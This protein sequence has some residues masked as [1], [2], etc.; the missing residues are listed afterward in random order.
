MSVEWPQGVLDLIP[1]YLGNQRWYANA[2]APEAGQ[3]RVERTAELWSDDVG[4]R[5]LLQAVVAAG[6]DYYHLLVGE[7]PA[8]ERAEFLH[9][10]EDAVLGVVGDAYYYDATLDS[11]LARA[12]LVVA[13]D[14]Q[15]SAALARQL[16]VE[17]SNTSLVY[18]DRL[19]LKVFRHLQ[20]GR[21]PDVEVTTALASAGFEH[22]AKPLVTWRDDRFDLAFGQRFLAGGSEGWA[23]ALT[24]LRDFYNGDTTD[25]AE[26]GGDFAAEAARLGRV[27][28]EMHLALAESFG[29]APTA[30]SV[31]TWARLVADI[32]E[33]LVSASEVA[34]KDLLEGAGSLLRRLGSVREPGPVFRVHGDY[35][36]GQVMRSD[37]GWF[38]LD[39]EGEPTKPLAERT[40]PMSPVKDVSSMIRSFH[41]AS[42]HVLA[43][44]PAQ[45][46]AQIESLPLAWE[47]HNRQAFLGGYQ[48]ADGIQALLPDPPTAAAAMVAYEL[49]KSLYELDYEQ[50][51]RPEWVSIPLDALDRIIY[52]VEP[53]G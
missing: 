44:R 24:S 38:V 31:S 32:R 3:V 41:Y 7:R 19:I 45:D 40:A 2:E 23:L 46:W 11:E 37:A 53:G 29:I 30:E 33:R 36:L 22:V 26:A 13:S 5:R 43:E 10:R 8:G 50:R 39:F 42:R 9:T 49:D 6:G 16:S 25:P 20:E 15:E 35:H 48:Q 14:G 27:T 52:G 4:A 1:E 34:K 12:L 21:N 17:Q 47:S 28:A 51:H 18:D